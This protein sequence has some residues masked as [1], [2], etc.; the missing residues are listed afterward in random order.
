MD[1]IFG[2]IAGICV[3]S[4]F[5]LMAV[6][7]ADGG[8]EVAMVVL[9]GPVAWLWVGVLKIIRLI[10]SSIKHSRFKAL[11]VC[12]DGEIRYVDSHKAQGVVDSE[13]Y[14]YRFVPFKALH[15]DVQQWP[16]EYRTTLGNDAVGNVRYCP[17]SV[18]SQFEKIS[19]ADYQ[20]AISN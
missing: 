16:K 8:H 13:K 17:K 12:P 14:K 3:M 18:W 9:C 6:I 10:K 5:A 19:K 1:W 11:L 15:S 7:A 4:F 20:S 2:F